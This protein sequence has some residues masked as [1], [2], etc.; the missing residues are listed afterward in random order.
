M[1]IAHHVNKFE[2]LLLFKR[3]RR[4]VRSSLTT[5]MSVFD[6]SIAKKENTLT[7]KELLSS[8]ANRLRNELR[9]NDY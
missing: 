9:F 8:S 2:S 1:H 6:T 3:L 5:D 4:F 7:S